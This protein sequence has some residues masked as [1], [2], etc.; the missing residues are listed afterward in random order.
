[1]T[2]GAVSTWLVHQAAGMIS[3]QCEVATDEALVI[4]RNLA[5]DEDRSLAELA[6]AVVERRFRFAEP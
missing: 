1:V 4:L 6:N 5:V 3:A 2:D